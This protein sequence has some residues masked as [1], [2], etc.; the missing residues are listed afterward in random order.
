MSEPRFLQI[1]FLLGII[2]VLATGPGGATG[3][4][5]DG[6]NLFTPIGSTSTNLIDNDGDI[7][8]PWSSGY[9]PRKS[10][11]LMEDSILLRNANTEALRSLWA[12]PE[13]EPNGTAGTTPDST[14]WT[15]MR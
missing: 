15:W 12:E 3:A 8:H 6:Y 2:T 13:G 11:Y 14:A 9:R 7:V 4:P 1:V 5:F 10:V